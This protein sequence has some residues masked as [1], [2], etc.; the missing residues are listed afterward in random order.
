MGFFISVLR[1]LALFLSQ[2]L[3]NIKFHGVEHI[4]KEGACIVTPNHFTYADPIW[5]TI[6]IYRRVRYMA[7]SRMFEIPLLGRVMRLFGAFPVKVES[8]DTYAQREA[9]E[10]LR[11]GYALVI[12]PEGGRSK[13][14]KLMPFKAGAFRLAITHG[15]PILPVT[16]HEGAFEIW[17]PHR[18]F[19]RTGNLTITFH[20]PIAVQPTDGEVTKL[21][22]KQQAR[23]LAKQT[24]EVVASVLRPETLDENPQALTRGN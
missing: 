11:G 7:W 20:P 14:G 21:E 4:P 12:F 19:P 5:I 8:T 17:P 13:S 23:E 18:T 22:L 24:Y 9:I 15:I 1:P 2:L 6:P 10:L 3:F 16:I